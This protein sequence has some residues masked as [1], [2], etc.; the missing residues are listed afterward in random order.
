MRPDGR[1]PF[2]HLLGTPYVSL[3]R[4][5]GE[6]AFALIPDHEV[7]AAKL[8]NRWISGCLWG[9][10]ASSDEHLVGTEHGLLKVWR[11]KI[12][13]VPVDHDEAQSHFCLSYQAVGSPVHSVTLHPFGQAGR[14]P[15]HCRQIWQFRV[16]PRMSTVVRCRAS[17]G[18]RWTIH[19]ALAVSPLTAFPISR[20]TRIEAQ[21]FWII[22]LLLMCHEAGARVMINM[23]AREHGLGP[24]QRIRRSNIRGRRARTLARAQLAICF[25]V[26]QRA[27]GQP[28]SVSLRGMR[29]ASARRGFVLNS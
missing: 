29:V 8:T 10:D 3:L 2:Q 6:S 26:G 11:C 18:Q 23:F 1:T 16:S 21:P 22:A 5:F 13:G 20:M 25:P 17:V 12:F 14:A 4:M 15:R 19:D 28:T 9:R 27:T 7:S 24:F